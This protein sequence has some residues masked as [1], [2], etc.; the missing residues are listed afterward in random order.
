LFPGFEQDLARA[1]A[2]ALTVGRDIRIEQPGYDPFPQRDLGF[3][4]YSLSRP[5]LEW[6]VRQRVCALANVVLRPHCRVHS[7]IA[8]ADSHAVTGLTCQTADGTV[9]TLPADLVVEASG[10]GTLTLDLLQAHGY[11]LPEETT[12]GVDLSYASTIF[13][14]PDGVSHEWQG[15]ITFPKVPEQSRGALL[16]PIEGHCWHLSVGG[17]QSE[18]PPGDEVGL[19]A[20]LQA[21][22]TPTIFQAV[23]HAKRLKPIARWHFPQS[24]YRHYERLA[25]FPR[26]LVLLGDALCRFNPIY[27]QGMSVAAQEAQQLGQLLAECASPP[28]SLH[29]LAQTFFAQAAA[30]IE[31]P[32]TMAMMADLA[33][34]GTQ[35]GRPA[36]FVQRQQMG[37]ALSVLAAQDPAVHKLVAEVMSLLKPHTVYE[38]Q[39]LMARV[40]ALVEAQDAA[41]DDAIK[42]SAD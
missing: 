8:S 5:Q 38:D 28:D 18:V 27:G 24:V 7:L 23:Q 11:A 36:D 29:V 15:V 37:G 12:I 31:T 40:Q 42:P 41:R 20:Y 26:G 33:F 14:I 30:I 19:M 1:G 10:Q 2:V 34:P 4:T 16:L 25:A 21:L 13:A 39:A 3:H 17:R 35:G 32:W 6:C 22:R 9:E